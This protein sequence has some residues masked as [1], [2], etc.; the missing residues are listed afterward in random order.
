MNMN[1]R[2][3]TKSEDQVALRRE[4]ERLSTFVLAGGRGERLN[5]LTKD[6]AKPAVVFGGIYRIIDFTLSNC[7]NSGIRRIN[8]LTQYKSISLARHI[9]LGWNILPAELTEFI[10]VIPAQQRYGDFWYRGTADAIFQNIYTLEREES[11]H[12]LILAGDHIYRM[13]YLKML[14]FHVEMDA[15]LTVA[16]VEM[17]AAEARHFGVLE[18]DQENRI[19]DFKEKPRQISSIPGKLGRIFASMGIYIFKKNVLMEELLKEG[20]EKRCDFGRHILPELVGKRRFFAYPFVDENQNG[21]S[22]WRDIGTLDAFYEANMDLVSINPQ[23]NLY[24][25]DWPIRTHQRQFPPAKTVFSG[26]NEEG[27]KG[28]ALDSLISSGCIISGGRVERSILSPLVRVNSYASVEESVLTDGVDI[29]RHAR[30]RRAI[31]DKYVQ[32]LPGTS[33]GFDKENDRKRFAVTESGVVVIPRGRVIGADSDLPR[34]HHLSERSQVNPADS[35][36]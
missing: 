27:R 1:N 18:V 34:W 30:V 35:Q 24:D 6:R 33:I 11:D 26:T 7:I 15:D 22:Y 17:A 8:I 31:I 20:G 19:I 13:D 25:R 3:E 10:D 32:I 36:S 14:E 12:V 16:A 29:G 5:P 4:L 2:A 23:F 28:E 9:K 21:E